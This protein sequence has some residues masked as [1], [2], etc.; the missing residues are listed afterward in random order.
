[1]RYRKLIIIASAWAIWFCVALIPV[2][3]GIGSLNF[4]ADPIPG[5]VWWTLGLTIITLIWAASCGRRD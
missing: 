3:L 5:F 4:A 1:M 2:F